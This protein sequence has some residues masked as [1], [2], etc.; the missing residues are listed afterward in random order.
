MKKLSNTD[1]VDTGRKLNVEKTSSERLMYIQFTFFVYWGEA[2]VKKAL[3]I[4]KACTS[5]LAKF[6]FFPFLIT[7]FFFEINT[8]VK[9]LP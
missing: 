7:M 8:S 2:D 6:S 1:R 9:V 5:S 3:L 4:K